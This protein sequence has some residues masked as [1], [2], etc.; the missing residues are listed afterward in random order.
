MHQI[1]NYSELQD[2]NAQRLQPRK[3]AQTGTALA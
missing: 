3:C 1:D 2:V